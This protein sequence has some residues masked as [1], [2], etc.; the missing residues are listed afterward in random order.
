MRDLTS[1]VRLRVNGTPQSSL[2][3][4]LSLSLSFSL[5]FPPKYETD[6]NPGIDLLCALTVCAHPRS[7]LSD[8]YAML[9]RRELYR[10]L[11]DS[12]A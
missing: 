4:S 10:L 1:M 9:H 8:N 5:R 7:T 2:S 12:L 6:L 11:M 3:L